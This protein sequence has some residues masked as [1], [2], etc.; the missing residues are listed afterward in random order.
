M[1]DFDPAALARETA[2]ALRAGVEAN[3]NALVL[4]L[5]DLGRARSD[6]AK[7][8]HCL[9]H[10]LSNAGKFTRNGQVTLQARR[11]RNELFFTVTDTGVGIAPAQQRAIFEPFAPAPADATRG[12]AGLGLAIASRMARMLGGALTVESAAGQGSAFTLRVRAD[13]GAATSTGAWPATA[14]TRA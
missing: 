11:Q 12:G 14:L 6:P 2:G 5:G 10:L 9:E 1:H 3:G 8:R 4:D 7:L 13:L